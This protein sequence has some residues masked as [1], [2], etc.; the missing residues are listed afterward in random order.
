MTRAALITLAILA[1]GFVAAPFLLGGYEL[2][3]LMVALLYVILAVGLNLATGYCGQFSFAQGA[4]Y[5]IGGYTAGILS[6]D[7]G[8][9]F[10]MNLPAGIVVTGLFGLAL[11]LPALRLKGHFLAIVTIAVQTLVYLGLVQWNSL[12]GGQN[13]LA[14]PPIG[15]TTLFGVRLFEVSSLRDLYWVALVMAAVFVFVAWRPVHSRLGREWVAVREDETLAGAVGLN[16]TFAKLT[17][18]VAS[19]AFAGGAGVLNAHAMQGVTPDDFQI[20]I[21]CMVVAMMVVGGRGTFMGPI[22]GA[23]ALT[24]L[25]ELTGELARYKMLIFGVLLVVCVT[26]APEGALGRIRKARENRE[27]AASTPAPAKDPSEASA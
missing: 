25:P 26:V 15:E 19:A 20:W 11:G 17:A 1:V 22:L 7:V 8:T 27:Q 6:R 24:I 16:T 21:S 12:T 18:F 23:I 2:N 10:W 3:V 9:G 13:G 5:G 14:V 4:F